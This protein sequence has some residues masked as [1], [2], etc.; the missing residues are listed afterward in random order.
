MVWASNQFGQKL[1]RN[2]TRWEEVERE[3]KQWG[4]GS[5]EKQQWDT[6]A[7]IAMALSL[8]KEIKGFLTADTS[9]AYTNE[10]GG[11]N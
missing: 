10:R 8:A 2:Q 9:R 4:L 1:D 11:E 7:N 3:K 5:K 6:L